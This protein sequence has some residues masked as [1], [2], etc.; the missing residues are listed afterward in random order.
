MYTSH[1]PRHE[2]KRFETAINQAERLG[3]DSLQLRALANLERSMSSSEAVTIVRAM[4]DLGCSYGLAGEVAK[5]VKAGVPYDTAI[6]QVR[7]IMQPRPQPAVRETTS[8]ARRGTT[9]TVR[10]T[11]NNSS[12]SLTA[13]N[14]HIP[15]QSFVD[16]DEN[17]SESSSEDSD[18]DEGDDEEEDDEEEDDEEEDGEEEDDD[19]EEE[20]GE[21]DADHSQEAE[22][23]SREQEEVQ[24]PTAVDSQPDASSDIE[25]T[26][27][28]Q[29]KDDNRVDEDGSAESASEG[30]AIN[31]A[32]ETNA[33]EEGHEPTHDE[34]G[35]GEEAKG[36][37]CQESNPGK[38][39]GWE[40]S[41]DHRSARE[42]GVTLERGSEEESQMVDDE[43]SLNQL[44]RGLDLSPY[45]ETRDEADKPVFQSAGLTEESGASRRDEG[46]SERWQDIIEH[47]THEAQLIPSAEDQTSQSHGPPLHAVAEMSVSSPHDSFDDLV[48]P[49]N[50]LPTPG[51]PQISDNVGMGSVDNA[52][53]TYYAISASLLGNGDSINT[54]GPPCLTESSVSQGPHPAYRNDLQDW[55]PTV[56]FGQQ[57]HT[58]A[59]GVDKSSFQVS[60]DA[61]EAAPSPHGPWAAQSGPSLHSCFVPGCS[62]AEK[63]ISILL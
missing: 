32:D 10:P 43:A 54:N 2:Q 13:M 7:S 17:D 61:V 31:N 24:A 45:L 1:H 48:F 14:R 9:T 41:E 42:D 12:K 35:S 19:D 58:E 46:P 53:D 3:F 36:N 37:D 34:A 23:V 52:T 16:D 38:S 11:I 26:H 4:K 22:I 29:C 49:T 62:V 27:G 60:D 20:D 8:M 56:G 30:G 21:N 33:T 28:D 59:S 44:M 50:Y 5:R 6:T 40:S 25:N 55:P 47:H 15:R 39:S 63:H 51:W 18:D 57:R